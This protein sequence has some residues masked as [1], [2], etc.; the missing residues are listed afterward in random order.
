MQFSPDTGDKGK[1]K[2]VVPGLYA[3]FFFWDLEQRPVAFFARSV[4]HSYCIVGVCV[5]GMGK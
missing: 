4:C 2:G 1:G 5:R 3:F